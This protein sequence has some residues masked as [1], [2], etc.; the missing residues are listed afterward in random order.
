MH[1][2][3]RA[4]VNFSQ[5]LLSS[6]TTKINAKQ[7]SS[8]YTLIYLCEAMHSSFIES[9]CGISNR[10]CMWRLMHIPRQSLEHYSF[11]DVSRLF[12]HLKALRTN[13]ERLIL[14][15]RRGILLLWLRPCKVLSI[16]ARKFVSGYTTSTRM[17]RGATTRRLL[18]ESYDLVFWRVVADI[19]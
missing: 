11:L 17:A 12:I 2:A 13:T 18:Y 5:A 4:Q 6:P 3:R 16:C 7:H 19:F 10:N 15:S 9:V 14:V 1:H 8:K